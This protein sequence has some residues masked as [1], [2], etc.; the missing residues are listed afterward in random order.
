MSRSIKELAKEYRR[1][2]QQCLES[3]AQDH[4]ICDQETAYRCIRLLSVDIESE[5][6]KL[7]VRFPRTCISCRHSTPTYGTNAVCDL[8]ARFCELGKNYQNCD[9]YEPFPDL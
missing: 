1:I 7:V 3:L 8:T 9:S 2:A 6:R 5:L 4:P